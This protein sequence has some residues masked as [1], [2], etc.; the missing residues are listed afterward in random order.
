MT[1]TSFNSY[2]TLAIF[3]IISILFCFFFFFWTRNY[4]HFRSVSCVW[5]LLSYR[6]LKSNWV[7]KPSKLG[8][9]FVYSLRIFV[10][11]HF[12][13]RRLACLQT[14]FG[15]FI[16]ICRLACSG[17]SLSIKEKK[18][19]G[20]S[21]RKSDTVQFSRWGDSFSP[22]LSSILSKSTLFQPMTAC[23]ISELY[24]K[25]M[26]KQSA[27]INCKNNLF[28]LCKWHCAFGQNNRVRSKLRIS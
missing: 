25:I 23:V 12:I 10:S 2:A 22:A 6:S 21:R 14:L 20:K 24:Y 4:I 13:I 8:L 3:F 1:S 27:G 26:Q 11:A 7:W 18:T 16:A 15:S 19:S 5:L 17:F 9:H 28:K